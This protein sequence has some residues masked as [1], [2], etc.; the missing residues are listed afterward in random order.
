MIFN[1]CCE[2]RKMQLTSPSSRSLA[3]LYIVT[4]LKQLSYNKSKFVNG[5][6]CLTMCYTSQ[7]HLF[8]LARK[9]TDLQ[10]FVD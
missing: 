8:F 1:S 6:S 4:S 9:V 5:T 2:E 7:G 10:L 3:N